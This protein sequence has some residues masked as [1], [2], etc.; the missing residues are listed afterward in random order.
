MKFLK[1]WIDERIND[2]I[3]FFD[4]EDFSNIEEIVDNGTKEILKK[5]D[6]ENKMFTIATLKNLDNPAIKK[7]TKIT[8]NEFKEFI[9]KL[10]T[11]NEVHPNINR[12]LGLTKGPDGNYFSVWEY[13][14]ERNLSNY[15]QTERSKLHLDDKIQMALDIAHGLMFLHSEKM[16]HGTLDASNVLIENGRLTIT[17]FYFYGSSEEDIKDDILSLG[18]LL[19]ELVRIDSEDTPLEY[20]QV[21]QKCLHEDPDLRPEVNE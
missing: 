16:A 11:F 17:G 19:H 20:K 18:H 2:D 7:V 13:T 10:K 3:Y 8:E 15:L 9:N 5:V 6:L 21:C 1:E 12:F 14:F 4:Y